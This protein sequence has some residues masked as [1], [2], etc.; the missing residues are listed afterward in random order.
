M[1]VS[2][3]YHRIGQGAP[4]VLLHG[5]P[6][7]GA[8]WNPIL[9]YL[10]EHFDCIVPD[11]RGFGASPLTEPGYT[12]EEMAAD[13]SALLVELDISAA[14]LAG[15]SMGGYIALAFA[16]C[17]NDQLLGLALLGT[18]AAPDAPERRQLR[19]ETI[20]QVRRDGIAPVLGMAEKLTF[21]LRHTPS[22]RQIIQ[23]QHPVGVMGALQAMAE[24]PDALPGLAT[25]TVPV[26]IVHGLQDGLVPVERARQM[27]AVLPQ[28]Y[29]LELPGVGHSPPYEAPEQTAQAVIRLV[30]DG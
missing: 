28:A 24:R 21:D 3:S 11:L 9:P 29:L 30:K 15:H 26:V 22:L 17:F 1:S 13:L 5:F 10:R 8:F 6:L 19:Y 2:L 14:F 16:R 4:L 7:D 12:L 20:E 23:R 18:Q 27:H 25:L